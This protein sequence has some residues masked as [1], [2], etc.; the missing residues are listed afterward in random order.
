MADTGWSIDP[1]PQAGG[2][3]IDPTPEQQQWTLDADQQHKAP[4]PL[5]DAASGFQHH[6]PAPTES[7]TLKTLTGKAPPP[8]VDTTDV[9]S[10]LGHGLES[11]LATVAA[12]AGDVAESFNPVSAARNLWLQ[13]KQLGL[14]FTG[15]AI[16]DGHL[17]DDYLKLEAQKNGSTPFTRFADSMTR[18]AQDLS[19]TPDGQKYNDLRYATTDPTKAAYLSPVR[20]VHDLLQSIPSTAAM[21]TTIYLTRGAAAEAY[22][23]ALGA[24][25]SKS[26]ALQIAAKAA[27]RVAT[28]AGAIG[29]GTVGGLQQGEQTRQQTLD[30]DTPTSRVYQT[31]VKAGVAPEDAKQYVA[32]EAG[33]TAGL[34]AGAVDALTNALEGPILGKIVSEGG[35]LPARVVKGF[36]TEGTQEAVQ[37][38]GEQVAQNYAEQQY[39][40]PQQKLGDQV[41]ENVIASFV[42]GGATG[43]LFTGAGGYNE[44]PTEHTGIGEPAPPGIREG[45]V[46]DAAQPTPEDEASP[47]PTDLITQGKATIAAASATGETNQVLSGAGMPDVGTR[48][49]VTHNGKTKKGAIADAWT[50]DVAGENHTGVKIRLDDGTMIEEPVETLRAMGVT[51]RPEQL[52]DGLPA[53]DL[54]DPLVQQLASEGMARV[55]AAQEGAQSAPEAGWSID[56]PEAQNRAP[57]QSS[58]ATSETEGLAH[59]LIKR[60]I[61]EHV[62]RGVAAGIIAESG[63]N[64]QAVNKT[65]GAIGFG[66][67]L[68]SRKDALIAKYGDHPTPEQQLDFLVSELNGGDKGG[69]PVLA[70]TNEQEALDRYIKLFMRPAAGKETT[71]DLERGMAALGAKPGTQGDMFGGP[72][73]T[74]TEMDAAAAVDRVA[75]EGFGD[76]QEKSDLLDR[77]HEVLH[78]D[79]NNEPDHVSYSGKAL[80]DLLGTSVT[81]EEA[82]DYARAVLQRFGDQ[83]QGHALGGAKIDDEFTQFHEGTGTLGIPRVE[84]PQIKAEHRGA[85]V[86]FLNARGIDH[87]EVTLPAHAILPS[88]LEFAPAKVQQAKDFTGGNRAI[89]I[90]ESNHVVD[91]HHQFVAA[92]DKGEE[93]R[94][95]RL[96]APVQK[97]ADELRDMPSVKSGEGATTPVNTGEEPANNPLTSGQQ[98][99]VEGA[100]AVSDLVVG[101]VVRMAD[102]DFPVVSI[103]GNRPV[104]SDGTKLAP[105]GGPKR[106]VTNSSP[107]NITQNI[108][109]P[110][111]QEA[112]KAKMAAKAPSVERPTGK[113]ALSSLVRSQLDDVRLGRKPHSAWVVRNP[114]TREIVSWSVSKRGAEHE[115][116]RQWD[117]NDLDLERMTHPQAVAEL[118]ARESAPASSNVVHVAFGQQRAS[119][120]PKQTALKERMRAK[121]SNQTAEAPSKGHKAPSSSKPASVI[122]FVRRLGGIKDNEGHDLSKGRGLRRHPGLINNKS[123][124]SVDQVGEALWEAGYIGSPDHRPTEREVLELLDAADR[125]PVY[126]IHEREEA[127]AANREE[128]ERQR[129]EDA[130]HDIQSLATEAGLNLADDEIEAALEYHLG[131]GMTAAGAIERAVYQSAALDLLDVAAETRSEYGYADAADDVFQGDH[132]EDRGGAQ[133]SGQRSVDQSGAPSEG[134][135]AAG[136]HRAAAETQAPGEAEGRSAASPANADQLDA[137]GE[138]PGDRRSALERQGEGRLRSDKQQKAPGSD[139][140]LF[141]QR[142]S[143]GDLLAVQPSVNEQTL[144]PNGSANA[145]TREAGAASDR[146]PAPASNQTPPRPGMVPLYDDEDTAKQVGW[147][148]PATGTVEPL[149]HEPAHPANENSTESSQIRAS[150]AQPAPANNRVE[151]EPDDVDRIRTRL[152]ERMKE[153]GINDRISLQVAHGLELE[154]DNTLAQIDLWNRIIKIALDRSF[155]PEH[156]LNHEAIH[157]LGPN[158][159]RLI[160]TPEWNALVEAAWADDR[161]RTW[162]QTFPAYADLPLADQQE[163][164]AAE[165][166]ADQIDIMRRRAIEGVPM[167]PMQKL[168]SAAAYRVSR[169]LQALRHAVSYLTTGRPAKE[170]A[171]DVVL[172]I[173]RGEV[174]KRKSR[175]GDR[176]VDVS[177]GR[178]LTKGQGGEAP[179]AA[180]L[181]RNDR[182]VAAFNSAEDVQTRLKVHPDYAAAKAGDTGA[183][184]RL[185]EDLVPQSMLD[186]IRSRFAGATFAPA[187]AEEAS[188]ANKIP[189]AL[190][191]MLAEH[192][193]GN[194]DTQII[195]TNR[196]F[197]TGTSAMER[198]T[199]RPLFGGKVESGERYVIVDDVTVM[200]GTLAEMANHIAQGGGEV[201]GTAL[202]VNASRNPVIGPNKLR[203]QAVERR[204]GDV[205]RNELGIDPAALTGPESAYLLNFRDADSLRARIASARVQRS[206]RPGKGSLPQESSGQDA[207]GDSGD[208]ENG[209]RYQAAPPPPVAAPF[210]GGINDNETAPPR[211]IAPLRA[212]L[213]SFGPGGTS[214]RLGE[215]IDNLRTVLQD[216]M[217]PVL[218]IQAR[219]ERALGRAI[220][221]E[222]NPYLSEELFHGRTG[223]RLDDLMSKHVDP[224]FS[225]MRAANVSPDELETFLYA[226]HA[227]ERNARIAKINPEF[228]SDLLGEKAAGSGMTDEEAAAIMDAVDESGKR[229]VLESLAAKVDALNEFALQTRVDA[230]LLSA[231]EADMWRRTYEHYVPLRGR[232]GESDDTA[233]HMNRQSGFSVRGKESRRAFGRKSRATDI[234]P[235]SIMQAEEAIV[236]A[237]QNEVAEA[238]HNL[239]EAAPDRTF[240]QINKVNRV[241]VFNKGSGLVSYRTETRIAAEDAPYTV[242][243]KRGGTEY[244]IT[245]NRDNPAAVRVASAMRNLNSQQFRFVVATFGAIN[246]L[247]SAMITRFAPNFIVTN[248]FRDLQTAGI[249]LAGTNLKG[250]EHKV[251]KD[252]PAA[253]VAATKG[254]FGKGKGEWAKWYREF[255][256]EGGHVAFN[257]LSDITTLR[258]KVEH[259]VGQAQRARLGIRSMLK[260][261]LDVVDNMNGGVENALRL[262]TYKNAVQL[263]ATPKQAASLAKNVTVNFNRKGTAGPLINSLYLF[264]N[265]SVQGNVRIMQAM[266]S[267]KVRRIL[268]ASV[269]L[270]FL[271]QLLNHRLSDKDKDGDLFY[272]KIPEYEKEHN[273]IFMYP[274]AKDHPI[275]IPMPWGYNSFPNMGRMFAR[276]VEGERPSTAVSDWLWSIVDSFNPLGGA[277]NIVRTIAPSAFDPVVDLYTNRDYAGRPIMPDQKDPG[278]Q[279]PN[280]QRYWK[281]VAPYDKWITDRLNELTGG[282]S[283]RPG[284]IDVS[285]EVLSYLQ[286]TIL[287][288]VGTF[289]KQLLAMGSKAI[290]ND[291]ENKIEASDIPFANRVIANKP[292]WYDKSAFYSRLAQVEQDVTYAKEYIKSGNRP[293]LDKLID[294]DRDIL[295]LDRTA[296]AARKALRKISKERGEVDTA[297]ARG[298][299]D[300]AEADDLGRE[301][302][303]RQDLVINRFNSI[304]LANVKQPLRP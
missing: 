176:R 43:G 199:S 274:G 162:A 95:I 106:V 170:T 123:G 93:V 267:K 2:W 40:D 124:K 129:E 31:M 255:K 115:R 19:Q 273:F 224:L 285:P 110:S 42:V 245:F 57:A 238:L 62:A 243:A 14:D 276:L 253:L 153:L 258:K 206:G 145:G 235:Y 140:G 160:S 137:F 229:D 217:L 247:Q 55:K 299:I 100:K 87:E 271:M 64:A 65:S 89:L 291:P 114:A 59:S 144:D 272:D 130:R 58:A 133:E 120:P 112:L 131:H 82:P 230:G 30:G 158:G 282:D 13:T 183:A 60:G 270:G 121:A 184:I 293:G 296:K 205:V 24:G 142:D 15:K 3:S 259:A 108:P 302:D 11:G 135:A 226:R 225:A 197:H 9:P 26:E 103:E 77:A 48:V 294:E 128:T 4:T 209:V 111:K 234:L 202:L 74:G 136:E 240:W 127:D 68:G 119:E 44:H 17:S 179:R 196:A 223:A 189:L 269:I 109:A 288:G 151:I 94:A 300:Q 18:K 156:S 141:D 190:A 37:G 201:V 241:P 212:V 219:V 79:A 244:R 228:G 10:Y 102:G 117:A 252:Y 216:R 222:E 188:G 165:Y 70:A 193:G 75:E 66:Q 262:A 157:A 283:V 81:P 287:G 177:L 96:K 233:G 80:G 280:S 239:V 185:V 91:G 297:L 36:I 164:A 54:A 56:T 27:G 301:L 146:G 204:F 33:K 150:A 281:S 78:A 286:T 260:A 155:S 147:L 7:E 23:E 92:H 53:S 73:R 76:E 49:D 173:D 125:K 107:Q 268:M 28:F 122:A 163:E 166:F 47:L 69:A 61:P 279:V 250:L 218:R 174:G 159:L 161:L 246:R 85:M 248:A 203:S 278:Q 232:P 99:G 38:A 191:G 236:R 180:G 214:Q 242:V 182:P 169:F 261:A 138:R 20:V 284:A 12:G 51:V 34:G 290:A 8:P 167:T 192:A 21:A 90:D 172:K 198:L 67:W 152:L 88:Q 195:E 251:M 254:E 22:T 29:E 213:D 41:A 208:D 256:L 289:A 134:E 86:N 139:G 126:P 46:L 83:T 200:G 194:L 16:T 298:T 266:K 231:D 292:A 171:F 39:V 35:N 295:E 63:G 186:E 215:A 227:P 25:F 1:Q 264:F 118:K 275:K 168:V 132:A 187:I 178:R 104:L 105:G 211:L 84:M 148:D 220:K 175:F 72:E 277:E 210:S 221:D 50:V 97:I 304:Y 249:N 6:A 52:P 71:G 116:E 113:D 5:L 149:A 257:D 263:G 154:R 181:P 265:A 45:A 303:S 237:E 207:L 32:S 98:S 101:D 143:T